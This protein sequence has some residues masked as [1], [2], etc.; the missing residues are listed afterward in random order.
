VHVQ[1]YLTLL[2]VQELSKFFGRRVY[3]YQVGVT[4]DVGS[5]DDF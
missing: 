2:D 1:F 3:A 5:D 4:G